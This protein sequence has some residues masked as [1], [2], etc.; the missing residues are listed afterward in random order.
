VA[1]YAASQMFWIKMARFA[2]VGLLSLAPTFAVIATRKAAA[3]QGVDLLPAR[4][5]RI[6]FLIV[7]EPAVFSLI[8]LAATLMARGLALCAGGPAS[9]RRRRPDS[10]GGPRAPK[11]MSELGL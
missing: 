5:Q 10:C 7:A 1:F 4:F 11:I 9:T 8:P 3:G 2:V 6:R